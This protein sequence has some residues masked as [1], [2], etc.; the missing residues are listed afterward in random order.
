M[1]K[2]TIEKIVE[3]A[4]KAPSGDNVQPWRFEVSNEFTQLNLYNLPEKDDSYFNYQQTASYIAHGAVIENM[5]IAAQHLGYKAQIE[6]FPDSAN[7]NHVARVDLMPATAECD[8]LY[9]AIVNR[10][11]NRF[12]YERY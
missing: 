6:L 12:P 3:A 8:P 1:D 5:T 4:A 7:M 9:E 11:T 2:K 10:C